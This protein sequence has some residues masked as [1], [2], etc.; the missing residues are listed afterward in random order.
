MTVGDRMIHLGLDTK[1]EQQLGGQIQQH[2]AIAEFPGWSQHDLCVHYF[3]RHVQE[4][5]GKPD[6]E[7]G[8]KAWIS[9]KTLWGIW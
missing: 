8:H 5:N 9:G 4:E 3:L 2:Y 6:Q 7:Q 1:N